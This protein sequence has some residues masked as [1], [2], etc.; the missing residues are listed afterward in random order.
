MALS[1]PPPPPDHCPSI[2]CTSPSTTITRPPFP[3]NPRHPPPPPPPPPYPQPPPHYYPAPFYPIHPHFINSGLPS[4][5]NS[6]YPPPPHDVTSTAYTTTPLYPVVS[7]GRGFL[8]N[9]L[10]SVTVN[11]P[12][13]PNSHLYV[14]R[15]GVGVS[16][17]HRPV[18]GYSYPDPGQVPKMGLDMRYVSGRSITHLQHQGSGGGGGVATV[19]PGVIK[20]VPVSASSSSQPQHKIALSSVSISDCNGHKEIRERGKDDSF[21][22]IRDRKVRVFENASIYALCRSWLRNGIPEE[23]QP[24]HMDAARSL[25][26]PLPLPAEDSVSPVKEDDP[27]E[28][29]EEEGSVVNLTPEELL[30]THIKRAKR[31]RSRLREERLQRIARYKTR[32]ALL[33]PLMVEQQLRNDSASGN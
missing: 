15:P 24:L 1:T 23:S 32:L 20:G 21:A 31:V 25:P 16:Y 19:M 17:P 7:S 22:T 2:A 30:Q 4:S 29:E 28:E 11:H 5:P 10:P 6:T 3:P 8:Q 12:P 9:P 33:L 26:R 14:V 13:N 18:F 27:K